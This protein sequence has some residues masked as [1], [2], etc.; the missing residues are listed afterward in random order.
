MELA[1]LV[2]SPLRARWRDKHFVAEDV[3]GQLMIDGVAGPH[4][5]PEV[6]A[7]QTASGVWHV[8]RRADGASLV[9]DADG[10]QVARLERHRL[11]ATDII[12]N[13]GETFPVGG[14][15]FALRNVVRVG[16]VAKVSAPY[17]FPNRY[18]TM[19][20]GD[21]LL[22]HRQRELVIAIGIYVAWGR[23][24]SKIDASSS[25]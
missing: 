4:D 12:L 16:D 10:R 17:F 11:G 1:P 18:V 19:S 8:Q 15:T 25:S 23:I 3:D 6:V 14:G 7:L 2:R 5:G 20:F 13:D 21:K 22:S 9:F 24:Q